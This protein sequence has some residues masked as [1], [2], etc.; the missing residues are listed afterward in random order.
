MSSDYYG[1]ADLGSSPFDEF[2]AR[3]YGGAGPSRPV[4]RVDVTRLMSAPARELLGT[5]AAHVAEHGGTDLDTEH[6]LWAA[7]RLEPTRELLARAGADPILRHPAGKC[8][9]PSGRCLPVTR[10]AS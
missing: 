1:P 5:A 8:H 6:L 10:T 7:A 3:I 9:R 4:Q 2:L